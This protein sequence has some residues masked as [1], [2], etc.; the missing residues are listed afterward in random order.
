MVYFQRMELHTT[1]LCK[2]DIT[3]NFMAGPNFYVHAVRLVKR[4]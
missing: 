1:E 3:L 4:S 2:Y